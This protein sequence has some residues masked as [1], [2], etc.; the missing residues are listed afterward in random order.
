MKICDLPFCDIVR[1]DELANDKFTDNPTN[2]QKQHHKFLESNCIFTVKATISPKTIK[3]FLSSNS[4]D[5]NAQS[6]EDLSEILSL[7]ENDDNIYWN[8]FCKE[9]LFHL[10]LHVCYLPNNNEHP[11]CWILSKLTNNDETLTQNN[12][13]F[14]S[15]A[16]ELHHEIQEDEFKQKNYRNSFQSSIYPK[17]ENNFMVPNLPISIS[18]CEDKN[19]QIHDESRMHAVQITSS[20]IDKV[21]TG[22]YEIIFPNTNSILNSTNPPSY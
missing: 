14:I 19:F 18:L 9:N 10:L 22:A 20:S 17:I 12:C 3:T 16:Y 6:K 1:N 13:G 7:Q 15:F 2:F 5:L 8:V 11:D 4:K 21:F